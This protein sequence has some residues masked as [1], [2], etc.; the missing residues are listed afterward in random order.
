MRRNEFRQSKSIK[1][2]E[3]RTA[4]ARVWSTMQNVTQA[5][6]LLDIVGE[7]RSNSYHDKSLHSLTM[8]CYIGMAY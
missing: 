5:K 6:P 2:Q 8:Y 7:D 3:L 4:Y 1:E